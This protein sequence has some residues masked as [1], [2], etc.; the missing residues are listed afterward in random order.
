MIQFHETQ[1]GR[2]FYERD[3]PEIAKALREISKELARA[4]D[5]KEAELKLK[6]ESQ[7]EVER[8]RQ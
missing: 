7:K 8:I 1:M 6:A 5:L 3:I 4:N 2:K